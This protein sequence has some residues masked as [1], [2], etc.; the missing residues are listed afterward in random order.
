MN[1]APMIRSPA[2]MSWTENGISHCLWLGAKVSDTP[3]WICNLR[4]AHS[5]KEEQYTYV[6][7]EAH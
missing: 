7:P 3:N 5:N 4:L 1:T 6:D 2:G